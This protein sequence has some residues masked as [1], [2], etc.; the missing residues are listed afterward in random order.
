MIYK[1]FYQPDPVRNPKRETTHTL[2]LEAANI[3]D[4]TTLVETNTDY[5]IELVEPLEGNSLEYEQKSPDFQ[6]T[7]F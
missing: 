2:Y 6:L 4:A 7:E 1:V 3:A 5:N